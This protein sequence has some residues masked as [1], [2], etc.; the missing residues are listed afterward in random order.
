MMSRIIFYSTTKKKK[1]LLQECLHGL[2][3]A[4]DTKYTSYKKKTDQTMIKTNKRIN[5]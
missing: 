1:F 5:L 3:D 4:N 2:Q